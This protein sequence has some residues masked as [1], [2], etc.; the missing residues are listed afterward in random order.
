MF[1][2]LVE[3]MGTVRELVQSPDGTR[4][5]VA[6]VEARQGLA[7]GD[8]VCVDGTC[9]TIIDLDP[10][11]FWIG[12]SPETLIKTNLG[13]RKVGDR[14]N[15]E[16]SLL[17]GGRLGGHY[18]Q[19]HVDGVG[20]VVEMQPDGDSLRVWFTAPDEL[21][22][23]IVKKGYICLDGVSLTIT[24][25]VD[26]RFGIALVAYT[27]S[28][29]TLPSKGV[30]STVNLEVDVFAKYVESLLE[31]RVERDGSRS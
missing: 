11:G 23:Y 4:L 29:I 22:P 1:T 7:L 12:L 10:E 25:K 30:G 15:L 24:D 26:G 19:G 16:R 3:E 20:Q 9:L 5:S 13:E 18:V 31:G 28:K 8:S 27:Q 17:V 6:S 2:G 14:V 21:M